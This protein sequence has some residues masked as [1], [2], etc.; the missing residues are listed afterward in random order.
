MGK[1]CMNIYPSGE[2]RSLE[3]VNNSLQYLGGID[4]MATG[5]YGGTFDYEA[6]YNLWEPTRNDPHGT[7]LYFNQGYGSDSAG[8]C[9]ISVEHK[10]M[11]GPKYSGFFTGGETY[12]GATPTSTYIGGN[13]E[14]SFA[15]IGGGCGP[16]L[17]S[18]KW[19]A[20]YCLKPNEV[21][22]CYSNYD[23]KIYNTD[24]ICN[25]T[26]DYV[27]FSSLVN[28]DNR[29]GIGCDYVVFITNWTG[30]YVFDVTTVLNKC[31][32][33]GWRV[34]DRIVSPSD[35]WWHFDL[36]V[37]SISNQQPIFI[38]IKP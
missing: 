15:N 37:A 2:V 21:K 23:Q 16:I 4:W 12:V 27:G 5:V 7:Q 31:H 10:Q 36:Q 3:L 33:T 20:T 29:P 32:G 18:N 35:Y 24:V 6:A 11:C 13:V 1:P 25:S 22:T 19:F 34:G 9:A 26:V 38:P 8:L 30:S 17:T 14:A 28:S